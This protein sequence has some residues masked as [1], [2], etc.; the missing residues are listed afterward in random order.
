MTEKELHKQIC[1]YLKI[2]Y[3]KAL[4]TTD[5]SGIRLTIGQATQLKHL[6]SGSGWPDIFIFEP[7]K[8]NAGLFLEVKKSVSE[9]YKKNGEYVSNKHIFEQVEMHNKLIARGFD[10]RFTYS[11]EDAK[12][13]IDNYFNNEYPF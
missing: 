2:Q 3:P 5:L 7:N 9:V 6:R 8:S 11:F 10:V 12:T 4:F 1:H 13:K